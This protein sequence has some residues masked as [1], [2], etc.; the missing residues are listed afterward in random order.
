MYYRYQYKNTFVINF[1][2]NTIAI[3]NLDVLKELSLNE[4]LMSSKKKKQT[5]NALTVTE[6]QT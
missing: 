3:E 5:N 2:V 6:P 4:S 1:S